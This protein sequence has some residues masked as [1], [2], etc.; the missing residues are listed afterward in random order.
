MSEVTVK[1]LADVV[2][3]PPERLLAQLQEAGLE[4]ASQDDT[5]SENEKRELLGFL[6]RSHGKSEEVETGAPKKITL[7]RKTVSELSQPT[8]PSRSGR[9]SPRTPPAGR[10]KTV[11]VEVRRKR[12]YVKRSVV[13]DDSAK[14]PEV[15]AA[16]KALA[17]QEEQ[18]RQFE[19][20]EAAR[21]AAEETR[22][23]ELEEARRQA[24]DEARKKEEEARRLAEE[25]ARRLAEEE[26]KRREE[27]SR[28]RNARTS[29]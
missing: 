23:Q 6:R 21:K 18:R 24:E 20:E 26:A 11:S 10:G 13:A 14:L 8:A 28:L 22:R 9:I 29:S 1:Q 19:A 3:I 4:K 25:E 2:G 15:E 16:R 12:T 5:I 17:E 7:K 27:A